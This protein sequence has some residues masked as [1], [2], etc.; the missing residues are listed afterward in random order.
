MFLATSIVLRVAPSRFRRYIICPGCS[1]LL[2]SSARRLHV[3]HTRDGDKL[4]FNA[5]SADGVV[6]GIVCVQMKEVYTI[7]KAESILAQFIARARKPLHIVCDMEMEVTTTNC[8]VTISDYWQ[9]R[10]GIDWK[11]KGYTNGKTIGFLYVKNISDTS[12]KNHDAY[13]DGFRFAK[14]Q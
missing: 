7:E 3:R 9:D 2:H 10:A 4:Y 13:L 14:V 6:Y 5:Y 8:L 12:V 11:I 1:T